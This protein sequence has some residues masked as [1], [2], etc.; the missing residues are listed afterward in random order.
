[1]YPRWDDLLGRTI[2]KNINGGTRLK[3]V[4]EIRQNAQLA[5]NQA[6][7]LDDVENVLE[8]LEDLGE[9]CRLGGR[10]YRR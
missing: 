3:S 4:Y 8:A 7:S 10:Y 5:L 2:S 1:M 9:V 6:I